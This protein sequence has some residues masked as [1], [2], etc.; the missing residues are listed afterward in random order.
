MSPISPSARAIVIAASAVVAAACLLNRPPRAHA[1][2]A[3]PPSDAAKL[4]QAEAATL[5]Q[6]L[7]ETND[8]YMR[9][10]TPFS[11]VLELNRLLLDAQ[12]SGATSLQD[13]IAILQDAL[14]AAK[15]LEET[16]AKQVKVGL[17]PD[18]DGFGL[19]AKAFRQSIEARE[20]DMPGN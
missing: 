20:A 13:R 7:D 1:D 14:T 8:M 3:V 12:L 2:P 11:R 15:T 4:Y 5:R 16:I 9:G 19:E 17:A 18:R 6:A 10:L